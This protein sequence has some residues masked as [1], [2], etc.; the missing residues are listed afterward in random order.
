MGRR[1]LECMR[2]IDTAWNRRQWA[3]YAALL[4]DGLVAWMSGDESAHDKAE[5]VLRAQRFC[6]M[7]PDCQVGEPYVDIFLSLDGNKTC[8]V[9]RL[10]GSAPLGGRRFDVSFAVVCHWRNGRITEQREY[11]D[12]ELFERQLNL[13]N[14]AIGD[15]S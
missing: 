6:A 1:N 7:F 11:F 5:H 13:P 15:P 10:T 9:A 2:L 4:D 3:D 8:S 14:E 12:R